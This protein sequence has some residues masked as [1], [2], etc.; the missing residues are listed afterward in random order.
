MKRLFRLSTR[1]ASAKQAHSEIELH[2]DLK[3]QELIAAGMSPE[4]ARKAALQ[5]FGDREAIEADVARLRDATIRDRNRRDW[6]DELSMDLKVGLRGFLRAPGFTIA[7]LLTL[8]LGIGAN[9]AIFSVMR[10][11]LLRPLP[12]PNSEQL[13]QIWADHRALGRAEPEWLSPPDFLDL[14]EQNRTF[15][16]MAAYVRWGPDLTGVGDPE[17][18]QGIIASGNYFDMLGA[19][20]ALGRLLTMADDDPAAP[21][22]VVLSDALWRR[23]FGADSSIINKTITLSGT[24]A[25]VVGVLPR[26]FRAPFLGEAHVFAAFQRPLT[27][28]PCQRGCVTWRAIGR[29]KPG[30]TI[31]AAQADYAGIAKRLEAEYPATNTKVGAWLIPLH[32]QLTGE[33]RTG[34]LALSGAVALVLLIGCVNLAGLLLVRGAGRSREFSV[35]TALG[36]GRGRIVRQLLTEHALLA[37]VGGALGLALGVA[38]SNV[39]GALVPESVRLV[40]EIGVDTTVVLFAVGMTVLSAMLFGL[41][42]AWYAVRGS[43]MN[44]L[45]GGARS[46]RRADTRL[47]SGLVVAQLSLA[48]VLLAGAGLLMRSFMLMQSAD[49]GYR[50]SGVLMST[51]TF[52]PSRYPVEQ[53]VGSTASMVDRFRANS[54]IRSAELTDMPPLS[55]V[56]R[57][58]NATPVGEPARD[59]YPPS[60]WLRSVTPGYLNAMQFRL[61]AGRQFT[62]EDRADAPLVGI[63]NEETAR[64][65]FR[66]KDPIGRELILGDPVNGRRV[67]IVGVV[68]S[69]R[70]DG[71]R[72]PVKTEMFLPFEQSLRRSVTLVV[73]PA[74]DTAGAIS[75]IRS[76]IREADPMMPIR[77][78]RSMEELAGATV[79]QPRVYA[80]LVGAFAIAAL[81][82]AALG[83]YGVQA[84]SVA[85]REREIG[86]RLALGAAPS[87]IRNL[88]LRDASVLAVLGLVA[89]LV[90]AVVAGRLAE[91]MLY[92]VT[93]F[94]A[95]TFMTVALVLAVATLVAA[96][97]PA[98][99]AL[100]IDPL[101]SMRQ[102]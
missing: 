7:A 62:A 24:P 56:D 63:I 58:A 76:V 2:I 9:T 67:A 101:M 68:A 43:V 12:Y 8:A 48:V 23:R 6:F 73:E 21:A 30:V 18:I 83:V 46:T 27:S 42:P 66:G 34:V 17:G 25:I 78:I 33:S 41:A 99:R 72:Q 71:A 44:V 59:D 89:G 49:V 84:Y 57:D 51:L 10:S 53:L 52:P 94:D 69:D 26:E 65:Y 64:R 70:H 35:R 87:R 39:A 97:I 14:R 16:S 93:A 15:S 3:V 40:Q 79:A 91:T 100:R 55:P 4:D 88:V 50:T 92:G 85:Q 60:V 86:V 37:I 13:V 98:L 5:A 29:M 61:T 36:A 47:R 54:A 81:L 1:R 19:R 77:A 96:W 22:V 11:V 80:V 20:P 95:P 102:E 90:A 28:A 74:R 82:L 45:R 31:A 38:G 75:A 32:E